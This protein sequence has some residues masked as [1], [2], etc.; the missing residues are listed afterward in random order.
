MTKIDEVYK[1]LPV[2]PH[3]LVKFCKHKL[4]IKIRVDRKR[5]SLEDIVKS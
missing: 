3:Y 2:S 4:K 5:L 1:V